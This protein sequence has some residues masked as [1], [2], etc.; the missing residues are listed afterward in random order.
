MTRRIQLKTS[1]ISHCCSCKPVNFDTHL[2]KPGTLI[3]ELQAY[4]SWVSTRIRNRLLMRP[5]L[6]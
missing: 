3:P 6:S 4:I 2:D 1:L 5:L